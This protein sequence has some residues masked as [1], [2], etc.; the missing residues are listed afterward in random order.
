MN[1][2]DPSELSE[3]ERSMMQLIW[4]AAMHGAIRRN[5]CRS[6]GPLG[7][8]IRT[9]CGFQV[10]YLTH[11]E[12]RTYLYRPSEATERAGRVWWRIIDWFCDGSVSLLVG[13]MELDVLIVANDAPRERITAERKEM[14]TAWL[15]NCLRSLLMAAVVWTGIKLLRVR[16]VA[17]DSMGAGSV[18][19]GAMPGLMLG[20]RTAAAVVAHQR[21]SLGR[22]P[23]SNAGVTLR[24][25]TTTITVLPSSAETWCR[26]NTELQPMEEP[27]ARCI[28]HLLRPAPHFRLVM[29]VRILHRAKMPR[30]CLS[31]SLSASVPISNAGYDGSKIVLP[32]SRGLSCTLRRS[33]A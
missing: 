13:S 7:P 20:R 29:A 12:G 26:L 1:G 5:K 28:W 16:N 14:M 23:G 25:S 32:E 18:A 2:H 24:P 15:S 11:P 8:T 33:G 21:F 30:C 31:P 27:T 22:Q 17:E 10:G 6:W 19:A 9:V 3:L 4:H